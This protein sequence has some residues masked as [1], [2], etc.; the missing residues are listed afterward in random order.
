MCDKIVGLQVLII[1]LFFC[2][3]S[4]FYAGIPLVLDKVLL[5]QT[6]KATLKIGNLN[7]QANLMCLELPAASFSVMMPA[8]GV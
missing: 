8:F 2:D 1:R 6:I 7:S 4:L 3:I 5:R